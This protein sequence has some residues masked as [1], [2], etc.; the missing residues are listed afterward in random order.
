MKRKISIV[1]LLCVMFMS[2][3]AE[4]PHPPEEMPPVITVDAEVIQEE[5]LVY[6]YEQAVEDYLFPVEDFSWERNYAPEYVMLHFCSAV[7]EHRNDPYNMTYVRDTFVY[8]DVSVHY[9]VERDGTVRCYIPEDRVAWHAGA[10]MWNDDETYTNTMNQYAIGIEVLA[11]GSQ[12]DMAL[13]LTPEEYA[14]LNESDIGYTEEQ[15][16]ALKLLIADICQRNN[17]PMDKEHVIGHDAYSPGKTDPG[18]LFDWNRI[19]S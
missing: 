2:A 17:I 1:L 5:E 18:E 9:I 6:V 8:Y 7:V 13:Y 10:G 15:Y 3:C 11:I 16:E 12:A 4:K 19:F 14:A